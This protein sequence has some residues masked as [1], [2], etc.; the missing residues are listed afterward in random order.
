MQGVRSFALSQAYLH[1]DGGIVP[2][3]VCE[4][5]APALLKS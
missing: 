5:H 4:A 2:W 1:E 3:D